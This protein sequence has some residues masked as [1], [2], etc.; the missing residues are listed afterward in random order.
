[1]VGTR[2]ILIVNAHRGKVTAPG[3]QQRAV[4]KHSS[5]GKGSHPGW[6]HRSLRCKVRLNNIFKNGVFHI[7]EF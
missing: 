3:E 7:L 5:W 4:A 2:L 1:M 6:A